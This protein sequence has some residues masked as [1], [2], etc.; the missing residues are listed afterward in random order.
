MAFTV[1]PIGKPLDIYGMTPAE[2]AAYLKLI[3]SPV[4]TVTQQPI[5][6]SGIKSNGPIILKAGQKLI[7]DGE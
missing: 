3:S 2:Q 6:N 4:Q 7:F 5:F 1:N